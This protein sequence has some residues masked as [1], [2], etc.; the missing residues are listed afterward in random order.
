[1]FLKIHWRLTV[2]HA[3]I[4][5]KKKDTLNSMILRQ[6]VIRIVRNPSQWNTIILRGRKGIQIKLQSLQKTDVKLKFLI[7]FVHILVIFYN[8]VYVK[9]AIYWR[10]TILLSLH[11]E[12]AKERKFNLF[13]S[14]TGFW[15]HTLLRPF[16]S[17]VLCII[18]T[19]SSVKKNIYQWVIILIIVRL[20]WRTLVTL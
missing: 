16:F 3:L 12:R 14:I 8:Y 9:T 11:F 7:F 1:M 18:C 10:I 2:T 17:V 4:C 6:L 19:C 13:A 15:I 20:P 5:C